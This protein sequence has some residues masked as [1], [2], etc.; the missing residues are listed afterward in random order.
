[1]AAARDGSQQYV[2]FALGELLAGRLGR[3]LLRVRVLLLPRVLLL[4]RCSCCCF[5]ALAGLV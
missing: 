5:V 4:L 1:M 2:G 3:R